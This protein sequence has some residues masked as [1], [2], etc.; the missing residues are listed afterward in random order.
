VADA[1]VPDSSAAGGHSGGSA[2]NAGGGSGGSSAGGA[3][4]SA[5]LA[6][7]ERWL[8]EFANYLSTCACDSET[9]ARYREQNATLCQPGGVFAKV[10]ALVETGDLV[11]DSAAA[12]ALFARLREPEPSCVEEPFRALKLDSVEV[13]SLASVFQ[14]TRAIGSTCS[15]PVTY[16]GGVSDCRE[17]VCAP[18]GAGGGTCVS[19]VGLGDEC[20]GSGDDLFDATTTRLCHDRRAPDRDGEYESSFDSLSCVPSSPGSATRVCARGLADG[21]PCKGDASDELCAGGSCVAGV[22]AAKLANGAP[23]AN[24]AECQSKAC[25]N[26]EPRIC[27]PL[28]ADGEPC[29]YSDEACASGACNDPL[30][31]GGTC[32]PAPSRAIGESCGLSSDCVSEGHGDSRDR[33]CQDQICVADLC[34]Q[35]AP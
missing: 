19:F 10:A 8:D 4:G 31:V 14:G 13:Y 17:G 27:G 25:Q 23:C 35:Y 18:N 15:S 24:H 32:G 22:C 26:S 6:F 1:C 3:S 9:A 12:D 5:A 33:V 16:K 29:S 20:D 2:G 7:C 21:L 11:Y 28:L 34:A 30:G